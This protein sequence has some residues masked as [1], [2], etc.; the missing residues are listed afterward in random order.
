[1]KEYQCGVNNSARKKNG[2]GIDLQQKD[3]RKVKGHI[4]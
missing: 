4:G 1:M 3:A 2:K